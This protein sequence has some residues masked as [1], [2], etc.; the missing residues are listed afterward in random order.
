MNNSNTSKKDF[1]IDVD[2]AL[3]TDDGQPFDI[4]VGGSLGLLALG[5][6]GI[7]IWREKI[8]QS[9]KHINSAKEG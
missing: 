5:Y 8:R 2:A 1:P 4:P 6:K 3:Q 9:Q 7:M